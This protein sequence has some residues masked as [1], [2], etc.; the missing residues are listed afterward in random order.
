MPKRNYMKMKSIHIRKDESVMEA[1]EAVM[2]K[3]YW[4]HHTR[5]DARSVKGFIWLPE[6][7]CSV[8]GYTSSMAK[9]VCPHCGAKLEG[10]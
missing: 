3:P 2:P 9:P 8:C 4:I 1:I 5:E 7:E 6:C 10:R